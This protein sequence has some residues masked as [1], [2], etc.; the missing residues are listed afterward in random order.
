M[1]IQPKTQEHFFDNLSWLDSQGT[2]PE[3]LLPLPP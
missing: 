2:H 3:W 1:K